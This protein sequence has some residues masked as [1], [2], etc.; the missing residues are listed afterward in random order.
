MK[1]C[2]LLTG[3]SRIRYALDTLQ[4]TW[5]EVSEDWD[6]AVS[7]R[8]CER[9]LE[10]IGPKLKLAIDAMGRMNLLM[11]EVQRDCES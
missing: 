11:G 10:P 3:A 8:F 2:D 6:D 4:L 5:Q 1:N 9:H 7:Q